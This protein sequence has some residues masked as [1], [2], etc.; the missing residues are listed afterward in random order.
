[1]AAFDSE[2]YG[3]ATTGVYGNLSC[4][5]AKYSDGTLDVDTVG[6]NTLI[7]T[8]SAHESDV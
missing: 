7:G 5:S 4:V 2:I 3:I 6:S 8:L 1:M